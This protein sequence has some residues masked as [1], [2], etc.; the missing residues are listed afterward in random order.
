MGETHGRIMLQWFL[1]LVSLPVLNG[2]LQAYKAKLA[3]G[4]SADTIAAD[5]A[6]RELTV[7][8]QEIQFQTQYRIAE[9]GHW[10]EPDKIMG[11]L[12]ALLLAKIIVW[13]IIL[14]LGVTNLHQGWLTT[15]CNLILGFYFG[16]RGIEN[17]AKII[18][19]VRG[20]A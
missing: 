1:N 14:G 6:A 13:D 7:Q 11:Y 15:T 5:L 10:W 8:A 19:S 18:A 12:V 4:T 2:I 9:L 17:V 20:K 3:A 16:K